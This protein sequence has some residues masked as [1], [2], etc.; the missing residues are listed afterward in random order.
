MIL[1]KPAIY[2]KQ[3]YESTK[4][5]INTVGGFELLLMVDDTLK[6]TFIE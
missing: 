3:T 6:W 2:H 1:L 5:T 4:G